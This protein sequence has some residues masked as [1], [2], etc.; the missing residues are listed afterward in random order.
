MQWNYLPYLNEITA[1]VSDMGR[2]TNDARPAKSD[3]LSQFINEHHG[4]FVV[5][6]G[7]GTSFS[8]VKSDEDA[9]LG[10]TPTTR[11]MGRIDYVENLI[12]LDRAAFKSWLSEH[13]LAEASTLKGLE[14]EGWLVKCGQGVRAT[15][16][17]GFPLL[18][19][20]QTRV[21]EL[22][23]IVGRIELEALST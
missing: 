13:G 17:R 8:G 12:Y 6:T 3:V 21:V 10:R 2:L 20:V 23:G 1:A 5:V 22:R 19:K 11:V 16:G 7:T 14:T 4:S 9:A 18:S 15:I